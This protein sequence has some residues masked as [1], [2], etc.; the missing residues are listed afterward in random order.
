MKKLFLAVMLSL[1]TAYFSVAQPVIRICGDADV[2]HV[3]AQ[4]KRSLAYLKIQGNIYLD[5]VFSKRM[6]K[7]LKGLTIKVPVPDTAGD[8][9]GIIRVRINAGLDERQRCKVLA[10]EMIHVKQYVK[11]NLR[12]LGNHRVIWKGKKYTYQNRE[13]RKNPWE[14][15]AY[16]YDQYLAKVLWEMPPLTYPLASTSKP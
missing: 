10:H 3:T 11:G 8:H 12:M 14:L 7:Q 16:R 5:I 13:H 4:V 6:P 2:L 9:L 15:E 1:L